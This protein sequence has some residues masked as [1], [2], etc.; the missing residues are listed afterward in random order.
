MIS[1]V[2]PSDMLT[3]LLGGTEHRR[4]VGT[5]AHES[6][7]STRHCDAASSQSMLNC[8]VSAA[9]LCMVPCRNDD[10]RLR[11]GL[12][13]LPAVISFDNLRTPTR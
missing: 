7:G 10:A 2:S 6:H 5:T 4:Q 9:R 11:S 13:C 12:L 3:H 8:L 1:R